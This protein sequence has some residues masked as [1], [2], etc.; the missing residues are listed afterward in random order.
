M[1]RR[2]KLEAYIER[3]ECSNRPLTAD[4]FLTDFCNLSCSYCRYYHDTGSYMPF[5]KF[6]LYVRKLQQLGVKGFILTGGGEPTIHPQFND[7]ISWL[8]T[9]RISYGINTNGVRYIACNPVFFKF[10]IDTGEEK[11]YQEIRGRNKLKDVIENIKKAIKHKVDNGTTTNI[12]VQCVVQNRD[13]MLS[14][15]EKV[16]YLSVDYIYFRPLEHT[17]RPKD[18]NNLIKELQLIAKDDNRV[19]ISYK[20]GLSD[21]KPAKCFAQWSVITLNHQGDV[22]YCCHKPNEIVGNILD[23]DIINKKNR[24]RTDMSKCE[25]PC[26]LSGANKYLDG[27]RLENDRMFV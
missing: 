13:D 7:I 21:Y 24:Y 26:R 1:I 23:D 8:E 5:E 3:V 25:Y 27:L 12:G 2:N 14:F 19:Q 18:E 20:F 16:K 9:N 17:H 22:L 10:S 15:Y 11:R 4:I 6:K